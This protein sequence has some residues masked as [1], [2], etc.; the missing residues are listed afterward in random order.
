[1]RI[2]IA[3]LLLAGLYGCSVTPDLKESQDIPAADRA[4]ALHMAQLINTRCRYERSLVRNS[5]RPAA[6]TKF[7]ELPHIRRLYTSPSGWYK[8][9]AIADGV[10]GIAY[11]QK[12]SGMFVCGEPMWDKLPLSKTVTFVE[13]G[14]K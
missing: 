6:V 8:A 14:R 12:A 7:T 5:Y 4:A 2:G 3:S 1:M 11:Y 9:E 13:V 10:E